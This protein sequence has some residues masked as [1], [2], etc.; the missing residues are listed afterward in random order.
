MLVGVSA[1]HHGRGRQ[2]RAA[3]L[4]PPERTR[5]VLT[6]QLIKRRHG[7]GDIGASIDRPAGRIQACDARCVVGVVQELS[8]AVEILPVHAE[9]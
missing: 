6:I 1:R 2:A 7:D 4:T 8:D 5:L 3:E 9:L